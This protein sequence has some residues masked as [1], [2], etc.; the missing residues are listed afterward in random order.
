MKI[1]VCI[2][3]VGRSL[4]V[5]NM[6]MALWAGTR[7]P[8]E[9]II[10]DQTEP[11]RRNRFA[12]AQ[13]RQYEAHGH[14]RIIEQRIKSATLSRNHAARETNA[15][16]LVYVDDDAFIPP[17]FLEHYATLF[18]D[19]SVDGA[20]GMILVDEAD[21]GTIDTSHDYPSLHDGTTMLRGGNFALRREVMFRVGG[22]DENLVGAANYED[23]D[24]AW[25]LHDAGCK[26]VWSPKPWLYHLCYRS[27]GGRI[28]NPKAQRNYAYNLFYY[29]IRHRRVTAGFVMGLL[30]QRV[31]N[32]GNLAR[33]WT[34]PARVADLFHGYGT[35]KRTA[36]RGP[37]LPLLGADRPADTET[38]IA[39]GS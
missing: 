3:T 12:F 36:R 24:L 32:R 19:Q 20:T 34:I 22:L 9:I 33:P 16:L 18:A 26:V 35:A 8:D 5:L 1:A 23:A 7:K 37:L 11:E 31:F 4:F 10:V 14:C 38:R 39:V 15:D 29:Q 25:R 13:L 2:P 17:D 6:V 30:R 21:D 27:G 28:A